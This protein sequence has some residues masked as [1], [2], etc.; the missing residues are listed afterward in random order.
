MSKPIFWKKD[1]NDF[2]LSSAEIF[3]SMQSVNVLQI[4]TQAKV[5]YTHVHRQI[6][7]KVSIE[8]R[9]WVYIYILFGGFTG[10]DVVDIS[11]TF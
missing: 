9:G 4:Y 7:G 1:E 2:K 8:E 11:W 6:A 5:A 3:P 10:I